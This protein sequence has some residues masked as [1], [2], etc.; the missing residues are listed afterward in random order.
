MQIDAARGRLP[1]PETVSKVVDALLPCGLNGL[2]FYMECLAESQAFPVEKIDSYVIPQSYLKGLD[3]FC[4]SRGVEFIPHFDFPGHQ[5]NLLRVP[6]MKRYA[7]V[8]NCIRLD[9][10]EAREKIKEYV[11]EV[12][13]CFSSRYVHCGGD[14]TFQLGMGESKAFYQQHG[15]ENTF[16]DF[17][18]ELNAH[19]KSLGKTLICYADAPIVYPGLV[20][21]ID[22]DVVMN[23]WAYCIEN[24]CYEAENYHYS[25]HEGGTARHPLW[26]TANCMAEY[27]FTPFYRLKENVDIWRR[28]GE[29]A[30]GLT[31][32]DWGTWENCNPYVLSVLGTTYALRRF[33]NPDYADDE[34]L[35]DA[36]R[37]ILG[38]EDA[39]FMEAYR[40]LLNAS[41]RD[42]WSDRALYFG[43]P[44]PK[45]FFG[46][47]DSRNV[48]RLAC[49]SDPQKFARLE[50]DVR[51]AVR[52]M[53]AV[54]ATGAKE[55]DWLHD[56]QRLA[57]R[58]LIAIVRGK[59]CF[60]HAF[61]AGGVWFTNEDLQPIVDDYAE[62]QSLIASDR[63]FLCENW[64]REAYESALSRCLALYDKTVAETALAVRL[65][66]NVLR[67]YPPQPLKQGAGGG[68]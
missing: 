4:K 23:N 22:P 19:V 63:A 8:A 12:A 16:A 42:Y 68:L 54:D 25:R 24:E 38:K 48:T 60:R 46:N 27:V 7:D 14:E 32:S 39:A 36:S 26:V 31:V 49:F 13:A 37:L 45:L 3:A 47:P 58:V 53:E 50:S 67:A 55:P 28:L 34:F 11:A 56:L 1:K 9:L 5:E 41:G 17:V 59:L 6:E 61:D 30:I 52:L 44:L 35:R 65:P 18:N 62:Y 2:V 64:K 40:I 20:D 21:L 66:E 10:P 51:L 33:A 15:F 29:R 57:N 43:P